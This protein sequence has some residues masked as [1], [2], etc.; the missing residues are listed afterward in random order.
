M[1]SFMN[2][3]LS[4]QSPALDVDMSDTYREK[5]FITTDREIY[6]TGEQIRVKVYEMDELSCQPVDFSKIAYLEIL[7]AGN[8]PVRQAKIRVEGTSGSAVF[9]LSDTLSSG[10]YLIRA[11]TGWMENFPEDLFAY[12]PITVINPFRDLNNLV[13]DAAGQTNSK[14]LSYAASKEFNC[15]ETVDRQVSITANTDRNEYG[16]KRQGEDRYFRLRQ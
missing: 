16:D 8:N 11:Y 5:L 2:I 7:N 15:N 1:T 12:T 13:T 3:T 10:N 14:G 4:G 6:I 9:R